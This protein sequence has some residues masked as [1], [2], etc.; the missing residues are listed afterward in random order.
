MVALDDDIDAAD[1]DDEEADDARAERGTARVT[2]LRPVHGP[3]PSPD[4]A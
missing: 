4:G 3:A 1:S 2:P